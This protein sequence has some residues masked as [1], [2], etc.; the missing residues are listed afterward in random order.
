MEDRDMAYE[1]MKWTQRAAELWVQSRTLISFSV[2]C[3]HR[4]NSSLLN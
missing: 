3:Y 4:P 2:H 1:D